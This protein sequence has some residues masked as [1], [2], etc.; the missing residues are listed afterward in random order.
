MVRGR[1]AGG[2]RVP[3]R[4]FMTD[5][6]KFGIRLANVCLT[7]PKEIPNMTTIPSRRP[8]VQ[9]SLFEAKPAPLAAN[10]AREP[11]GAEP[12]G[13]TA[14]LRVRATR[15]LAAHQPCVRVVRLPFHE[16][17]RAGGLQ[18]KVNIHRAGA[19]AGFAR[20][21]SEQATHTFGF[22]V[23]AVTFVMICFLAAALIL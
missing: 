2:M 17:P 10:R 16:M 20:P 5:P 14:G 7:S 15:R 21:A 11:E 4:S 12:W 18:P 6:L 9:K 13:I 1:R 22:E 8:V 3:G 19:E 23:A